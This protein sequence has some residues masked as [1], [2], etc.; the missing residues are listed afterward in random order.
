MYCSYPADGKKQGYLKVGFIDSGYRYKC[1][2][3]L[4]EARG[5]GIEDLQNLQKFRVL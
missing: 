3:E 5:T 4:G 1:L 2:S